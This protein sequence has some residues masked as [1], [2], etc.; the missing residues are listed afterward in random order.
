[1]LNVLH[2]A[3]GWVV[4]ITY[5]GPG[6]AFIYGRRIMAPV[7]GAI[8]ALFAREL[9]PLYP[10]KR[11]PAITVRT[12]YLRGYFFLFFF[13]RDLLCFMSREI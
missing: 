2:A 10:G 13:L 1:M 9:P 4:T 5:A 8:I 12:L 11:R 7:Q 3:I 6:L